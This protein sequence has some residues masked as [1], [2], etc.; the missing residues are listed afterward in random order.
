MMKRK[1]IEGIKKLSLALFGALV[2]ITS[3][4]ASDTLEI[5]KDIFVPNLEQGMELFQGIKAFK[6]GGPS[7]ISCHNV[8]NDEVAPG[9]LLAKDLTDVYSR[10]GEGITPWLGAPPFPAMVSSYQNNVLE[11]D[12]KANLTAFLK[13]VNEVKDTQEA[14]DDGIFIQLVGG[15]VGLVVL[16]ILVQLLWSNR[17]RK[18]VK[19][20][21]FK[22]QNSSWDAKY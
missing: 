7:C 19:K 14:E 4:N 1:K 21:I 20:D 13:H 17:K 9:G 2:S 18:S 12:E 10:M 5:K 3:I 6:N 16:L 22:R 15:M 11:E 8:K